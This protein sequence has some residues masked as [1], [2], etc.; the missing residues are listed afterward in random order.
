MVFIEIL[1][2]GKIPVKVLIDTLSKFNTIRKSFFNRLGTNEIEL[3]CNLVKN[4]YENAIGKI[5]C[6]DLQ[7]GYKEIY[8]SLDSTNSIKNTH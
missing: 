3:T 5:C 2:E 8:Y 7:F 1:V 6:L 4:L